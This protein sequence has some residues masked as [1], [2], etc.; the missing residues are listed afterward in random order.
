RNSGL[1]DQ[2]WYLEQYPDVAALAIDPVEHYLRWGA[3]LERNP[4]PRF[5]TRHYLQANRDVAAAGINPLVHFIKY[6]RRERRSPLPAPPLAADFNVAVDVVV[7]VFNALEDVRMCLASVRDRRDGFRLRVI[8][9]NDGSNA[10]TSDWLRSFCAK[11]HG[12]E[13]IEH[14]RNR[15]Y[16]RAVNTGLRASDAPYVI[17]LNS[18]AIVTTGWLKGMVSCMTSE[19]GRG[20]VGPLSYAVRWQNVPELLGE[21]GKFAVNTLP[22]EFSPDDMASLVAVVARRDYPRT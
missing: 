5:D 21:D 1:F 16:T 6:G 8:V 20:V 12:F 13:L 2:S 11:T 18:D 9:V 19:P 14:D 4:G 15:G 22:G 17:T 10:E 7:P 3:Q